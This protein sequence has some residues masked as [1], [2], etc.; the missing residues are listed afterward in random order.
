MFAPMSETGERI[1]RIREA[2]KLSQG[3]LGKKLGHGQRWISYR[4]NGESKI[5]VEEAIAILG[6]LGKSSALVIRDGEIAPFME[7][8]DGALP[9]DLELARM[10]LLALPRLQPETRDMLRALCLSVLGQAS[11]EGRAAG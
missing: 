10:L 4:E 9:E 3:D 2:A 1:R 7:A 6:A 5:A 11:G 8:V